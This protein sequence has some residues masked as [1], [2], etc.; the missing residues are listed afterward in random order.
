VYVDYV[1]QK[2]IRDETRQEGSDAICVVC[3]HQ[4]N[5]CIMVVGSGSD[6]CTFLRVIEGTVNDT[7]NRDVRDEGDYPCVC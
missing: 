6:G 4:R 3:D 5:A 1:Y 2:E 7:R